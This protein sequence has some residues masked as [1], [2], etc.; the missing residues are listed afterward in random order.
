MDSVSHLPDVPGVP[1]VV[2]GRERDGGQVARTLPAAPAEFART[3]PALLVSLLERVS[4]S[5]HAAR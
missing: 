1:A 3:M 5:P 2:P 4:A